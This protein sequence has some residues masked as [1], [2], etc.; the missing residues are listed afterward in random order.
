MLYSKPCI[1][2]E[3]TYQ[4]FKLYPHS[5]MVQ[6]S[7]SILTSITEIVLFLYKPVRFMVFIRS[8]SKNVS[9]YSIVQLLDSR[10]FSAS[11]FF[12]YQLKKQEIYDMLYKHSY[13]F[14]FLVVF[15]LI[16]KVVHILYKVE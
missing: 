7:L 4:W 1:N 3:F 15:L 11:G 5:K 6:N 14:K 10:S 8:S 13:D 16:Y 2:L 12:G 9:Y